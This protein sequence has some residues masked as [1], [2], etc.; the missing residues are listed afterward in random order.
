MVANDNATAVSRRTGP[1][2]GLA[3][4]GAAVV[5]AVLVWTVAAL[6]GLDLKSP[7]FSA[8]QPSQ[9]VG[10][11]PVI[12]VSLLAALLGWGTY[13]L[14]GRIAPARGR[15]IWTIVAVVALL[16]SLGGPLSGTGTT[17][18]SRAVLVLLHLVVGAIVIL[19]VP[20]VASRR[21]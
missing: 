21:S 20:R 18:S 15:L 17:G 9:P 12:V 11:G 14:L 8:S 19:G 16:F 4:V 3:V 2:G 6:A 10:I 5:A 7:A 13:V 1:V